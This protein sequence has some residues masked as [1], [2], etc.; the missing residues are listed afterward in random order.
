L[1]AM[2]HDRIRVVSLGCGPRATAHM[3][4]MQT[5]GAVELLAA[6][7]LNAERLA[8][9]KEQ[10]HIP[11]TYADMTEM[12]G[13]EKPDLVDIV[14]P[15]TIRVG[16]VEAAIAAGARAIL[17]EKPIALR[18]SESRRLVELGRECLIAVNTQYRWF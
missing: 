18:P 8:A 11:R 12:I 15:P 4:A 2:K 6:S 13:E 9:A 10:F 3:A 1:S 16:I 14:T 17:I 7:D 5:C